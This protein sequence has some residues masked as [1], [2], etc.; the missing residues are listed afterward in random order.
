MT[1]RSVSSA[2]RKAPGGV[3]PGPEHGAGAGGLGEGGFH[4]LDA[5]GVG[6]HDLD[7]VGAGLAVEEA[8]GGVEG[9]VG[10]GLV[11]VV[12]ADREDVGDG[13]VVGARLVA[14]GGV[15]AL[16]RDDGHDVADA[17]AEVAGDAAA[18]GDAGGELGQV[19]GGGFGVLDE[20]HG[21]KVGEAGADDLDAGGAAV[22][23]D[24]HLAADQRGGVGDA[25]DGVEALGERVV[26]GDQPAGGVGGVV[27]GDVGVGAEDAVGEFLAEAD[28]H[29]L[30]DD[31]GGDAEHHP[32]QRVPGDH[33]DAALAAAGA[34]VAP[35]D[36][37]FEA[38]EGG[39]AGGCGR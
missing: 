6:D 3:A 25:G 26:V 22:G 30:D 21:L 11:D 9:H 10:A 7:L 16:R 8:L 31:E 14:E 4:F 2:E 23:G 17:D 39:G 15:H 13:I 37:P 35:G 32:D 29:R 5:V 33:R 36:Q 24:H 1:R 20:R 12:A 19:A 27:D 34:Q 28:H 38:G 18:Q